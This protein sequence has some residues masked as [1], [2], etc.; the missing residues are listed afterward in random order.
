MRI[1]LDLPMLKRRCLFSPAPS[2]SDGY[3]QW[4]T[5]NSYSINYSP[6]LLISETGPF[7][8][9][10]TQVLELSHQI[11]LDHS[12]FS[13]IGQEMLR[14]RYVPV[15]GGIRDSLFLSTLDALMQD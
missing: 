5:V 13:G 15:Y 7:L 14:G 11:A 1:V 2:L 12:A 9:F 6:D 3:D 8:S 4:S 10:F